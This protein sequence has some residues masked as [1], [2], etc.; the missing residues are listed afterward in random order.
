M[1]NYILIILILIIP[2][3]S[4][5][6]SLSISVS[7]TQNE[8]C[9]GYDCLYD[10]P[11]ILIN[12]VMV[13]PLLYDASIKGC[14]PPPTSF[15]SNSCDGEW[16]ELYNPHHCESV[17]ISCYFLGNSATDN[18]PSGGRVY[19]AGLLLPEG[20]IVPPR[21]FA[22]IRGTK[23]PPVPSH[24]LVTNGG[25]T[26]EIVVDDDSKV[27]I[28]GYRFWL[29]NAGGWIAI[30][31]KN[32][33]PQDAVAWGTIN[34]PTSQTTTYNPGGC[35]YTGRL[36]SYSQIP[37]ERK[38]ATSSIESVV[39]KSFCRIPDGGDWDYNNPADSTYGEC[40][41]ACITPYVPTCSGTATVVVSGGM[42]PYR[43]LWN[44]G[45]KQITPT[46]INL[47]KGMYCVTV[48]D[49]N[50]DTL[51]EYVQ[52][53][54]KEPIVVVSSS[55][56]EYCIGSTI[57]LHANASQG[58]LPFTYL[59]GGPN[60]FTS[61]EQNPEIVNAVRKSEGNYYVTVYDSNGCEKTDSVQIGMLDVPVLNI[62]SAYPYYCEGSDF[63]LYSRKKEEITDIE[64]LKPD[65]TK[66]K[67]NDLL[68]T[69]S[70]LSNSGSYLLFATARNGCIV[71]PVSMDITIKKSPIIDLGKDQKV[72]DGGQIYLHAN[73]IQ[74]TPPFRYFWQGPD[75]FASNDQ[76]PT[77]SNV[78]KDNEGI[79]Q[80]KV[81][82]SNGCE[83]TG[84]VQMGV[85]PIYRIGIVGNSSHCEGNTITLSLVETSEVAEAK[86]TKPN[87]EKINGNTLSVGNAGKLDAGTY[88]VSA[89]MLNG[90]LAEPN[91]INIKVNEIP[92]VNLGEDHKTCEEAIILDAGNSSFT[93][94]WNTGETT[95][96]ITI[97][98]SGNYLVTVDNK[99]CIEND[100]IFVQFIKPELELIQEGNLCEDKTILLWA[101]TN[102]DNVLW[103]TGL[104][105]DSLI[106]EEQ[107][108]YR[109]TVNIQ[110]CETSQTI[111]IKCS[112]DIIFPNAFIPANGGLN[113]TFGPVD[114]DTYWISSYQLYIYDRW[115]SLVFNTTSIA[116]RW[117]G[118]IKGKDA[119]AGAYVYVAYFVCEGYPKFL[120]KY[121]TALLIR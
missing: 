81:F 5:G 61:K 15:D 49:A 105:A 48:I 72:C 92:I 11:T 69:N 78:G 37:N 40:N 114:I 44:D 36:M 17:D 38:N 93:H 22:I 57:E 117:D 50:N 111:D 26:V 32:G 54:N 33:I 80:V 41:A 120:K 115:G 119:P 66:V 77:I 99:G 103:S 7:S 4:L 107:G 14:P 67:E 60:N 35:G 75:G 18:G 102:A 42:T 19:P 101:K 109:A 110:G 21:G 29:P 30:Y 27:H 8:V 25:N 98:E 95:H 65:G 104:V 46:A 74:G 91:S 112:C 52:V 58:E 70:T 73:I 6:Q 31:D 24:L 59:W 28:E 12:E 51:R 45:D 116:D 97:T 82:D 13:S 79:Y 1:K 94:L 9:N 71:E 68:I 85:F 90:C 100:T 89:V 55:L 2:V 62:I 34:Q 63:T 84:A 106:V 64:W 118:K 86:W 16:I 10:G 53:E 43:I 121:G 23:T 88:S 108:S 113:A 3:F 83:K 87:G 47:C 56:H 96:Q 39:G 76:K 20:T